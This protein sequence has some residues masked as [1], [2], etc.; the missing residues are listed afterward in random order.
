MSQS[1]S[2]S[3]SDG[4]NSLGP[5]DSDYE[6]RLRDRKIYCMR[7]IIESSNL[8]EVKAAF[9]ATTESPEPDD[10]TAESFPR[11][12]QTGGNEGVAR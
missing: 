3:Q 12:V 2:E 9:A 1:L 11:R 4:A 7:T 10:V 6:S 8:K 5:T